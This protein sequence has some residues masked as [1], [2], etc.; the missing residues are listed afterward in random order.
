MKLTCPADKGG[1]QLINE[2]NLNTYMKKFYVGIQNGV[3][4]VR[5]IFTSPRPGTSSA[6][7]PSQTPFQTPHPPSSLPAPGNVAPTSAPPFETAATPEVV[8]K[9][10][11]LFSPGTESELQEE[12]EVLVQAAKEEEDLYIDLDRIA[13]KLMDIENVE[14]K[15]GEHKEK[16]IRYKNIMLK[17]NNII[18]EAGEREKA[19]R[20]S[21]EAFKHDA[22]LREQITVKQTKQLEEIYKEAEKNTKEVKRLQEVNRGLNERNNDVEIQLTEKDKE[23]KEMK[24]A[25]GGDD[26]DQEAVIEQLAGMNK[27]TSGNKCN[28]C[29]KSFRTNSDLDKHVDAKH[30][31]KTCTYCDKVC[32]NEQELVRHHQD[33]VDQGVATV[34][35]DNCQQV[36][37]SFAL[38]RHNP[39]CHGK[40]EDHDC[41]E[42]GEMFSSNNNMRKH[43]DKVHKMEPVVSRV[44]CKH[45]RKGN[46]FKANKCGFSH[47]GVQKTSNS[48][49]TAQTS[50]K[51]P[52]CKNG[53][54]CDWLSN[55][56][57]SYF[58]PNVGVQKPWTSSDRP[59][60]GRQGIRRPGS[61]QESRRPGGQ[62]ES[63]RPG[64]WQESRRP[65]GRQET[66]GH[67]GRQESRGQGGRQQGF[68]SDREM[69][70][71]DGRCERIPNCP[72]IH[73]M[74]DFP[75]LR[76]RTPVMRRN[77]HQKRN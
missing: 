34:K 25:L 23:I 51:V 70:R 12:E 42:C 57:C 29:G 75:P 9:P 26:N 1:H 56:R 6:P 64:G 3:Q 54:S 61:Q 37:T 72:Y 65:G 71:F 74:E 13:T 55:G 5:N 35:C 19:L 53:V 49:N 45:W 68:Q 39:N 58:H 60:A 62:Q 48:S 52:A 15:S 10:R 63:R 22:T 36:F 46:C 31:E 27:E 67:G 69:C 59:D 44:V 66:R 7:S 11:Q 76:R 43:Y 32:N 33:C 40:K 20:L 28:A 18:K 30:T 24:E 14:E 2:K 38:K 41:P 47:V 8:S 73:S 16:L 21:V 17:K 77:N 50:S 4:V